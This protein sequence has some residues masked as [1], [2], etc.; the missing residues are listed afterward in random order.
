MNR[1]TPIIAFSYNRLKGLVQ[2]F[3]DKL[4]ELAPTQLKLKPNDSFPTNILLLKLQ[5]KG[6]KSFYELLCTP[7]ISNIIWQKYYNYWTDVLNTPLEINDW[8]NLILKNVK[9]RYNNNLRE[10]Q[11]LIFRNNS[12]SNERI[13]KFNP[14]VSEKCKYCNETETIIHKLFFCEQAQKLWKLLE[15]IMIS[16]TI[17]VKITKV[18]A[19]L[20]FITLEENSVRNV[21][22]KLTKKFIFKCSYD[23]VQYNS[24]KFIAYI[25]TYVINLVLASEEYKVF[26]LHNWKKVYKFM[27]HFS[28]TERVF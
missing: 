17:N 3:V 10:M 28:H 18:N 9:G 5:K 23:D 25:R 21:L 12:Y 4:N 22:A 11:I 2:P 16:S 26:D 1:I 6:C 7:G 27:I 24:V 8:N 14:T 19:I 13:S 15:T 20:G